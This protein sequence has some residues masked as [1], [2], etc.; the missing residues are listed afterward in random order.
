MP[1]ALAPINSG[2]LESLGFA[3][4]RAALPPQ[5]RAALLQLVESA[6]PRADVKRK[7]SSVFAVR[8]LLSSIPALADALRDHG[9]QSLAS[10]A[11][12]ST[13]FPIDALYFD[14]PPDA[15]WT[16]PAH[17]DRMMPVTPA[18]LPNVRR[19]HG[20]SYAEPDVATL[21][22]LITLRIHFDLTDS[23]TGALAIAPRS[24]LN[25][26]LDEGTI[27]RIPLNTFVRCDAQPG[28]VLMM[29]PLTV[30]RSSPALV[31]KRRRVLHLVFASAQP[32]GALRW[33]RDA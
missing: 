8:E 11:L 31:P 20:F 25:G 13:A 30:H 5:A 19:R 17:Q 33:R 16:V 15:N 10:Q 4:A 32:A 23:G 2:E 3:F 9:V 28:D 6:P 7:S 27:T 18:D 29:R 21:S 1:T 26:V 22:T 14:K 12:G 24:H